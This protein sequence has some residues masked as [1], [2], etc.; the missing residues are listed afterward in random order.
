MSAHNQMGR[1][2]LSITPAA[3]KSIRNNEATTVPVQRRAL[4]SEH[5]LFAF[6]CSMKS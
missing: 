6:H 4:Y 2:R 1:Q 5:V 3:E